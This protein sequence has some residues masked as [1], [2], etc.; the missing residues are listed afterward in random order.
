[1][2]AY[3]GAHGRDAYETSLGP[4][5]LYSVTGWDMYILGEGVLSSLGS[6]EPRGIFAVGRVG[7]TEVSEW[8]RER[9]ASKRRGIGG[10]RLASR[11]QGRETELCQHSR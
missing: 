5:F 3:T 10:V 7:G 9:V 8:L 6:L 11:G 2:V 1:M 4:G